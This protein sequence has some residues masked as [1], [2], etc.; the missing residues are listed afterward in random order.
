[1]K[2]IPVTV[3]TG[4]LGAG[5]TTIILDI[6]SKCD[7][8]YK[9]AVLKN[10]FGDVQVDSQL[11]NQQKD[12][13]VEEISNGCLC[14]VLVGQIENALLDMKKI[15][16]GCLCCVLVGQM[17]NA[18]LDMKSI[19]DY[20]LALEN[21]E[22]DRIIIET[23]GSAF[24]A[25]IAWQIRQLKEHFALDSI[26]TVIDCVNFTGYEDT[27]YTAKLQAQYTDLIVL[28]K[29]ELVSERQLDIVI[30]HVANL[31]D[32]TPRIKYNKS[33]GLS[34]NLVFGL[35]TKLFSMVDPLNVCDDDHNKEVELLT[36]KSNGL[37]I[38][39]SSKTEQE[40]FTD[41]L[42]T[43]SKED[44]FRVKGFV[45]LDGK[46]LI[47]NHAFGRPNYLELNDEKDLTLSIVVMGQ[48]LNILKSRLNSHFINIETE[49]MN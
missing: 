42:N 25:P 31:N 47:V 30:D 18:L 41:W 10:E 24:P 8:A 48:N 15:S 28:N 12:M 46:W 33:S 23:S 6:L 45:K 43:L 37:F 21:Y 27:S 22:I 32:S 38:N 34:T 44:V 16:N 17:E 4:F 5:K 13:I 39:N 35:D 3:F 19:I 40:C 49:Y 14:C 11:M 9:V 20:S 7:P 26:I 29:H 2:I 1:M 36:L